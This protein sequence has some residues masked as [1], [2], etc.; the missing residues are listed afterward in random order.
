MTNANARI[1]LR[2]ATQ[3]DALRLSLLATQVFLDTYAYDGITDE[4]ST[5]V[6]HD[7][8][9]GAFLKILATPE[10]FITMAI[11]EGALVGFA[12]TTVGR[13]QALIPKGMPAEL[14]RLYVQ[15]PF[16]KNGVGSA[17]LASH[18]VQAAGK[19][20]E[21]LWLTTWIENHRAR[22]FYPMRD[23]QDYGATFFSLGSYKVENRVFAKVLQVAA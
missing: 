4:I 11:H 15:E 1:S 14:D 23:Y 19:G 20:A 22:K 3:A 7:F 10:T 18:E 17:L 9:I 13:A 21:V 12:Q 6:A 8:S 5:K 16:T 2:S